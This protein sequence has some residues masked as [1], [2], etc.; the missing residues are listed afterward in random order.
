[1]K[2]QEMASHQ[3]IFLDHFWC[4]KESAHYDVASCLFFSGPFSSHLNFIQGG[5]YLQKL[6]LEPSQSQ[7]EV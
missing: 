4:A 1:M 3:G 6:E 7:P 5:F 2:L